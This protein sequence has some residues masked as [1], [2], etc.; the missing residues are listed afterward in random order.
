MRKLIKS[1]VGTQLSEPRFAANSELARYVSP[2][3][4]M[5]GGRISSAAFLLK[6]GEEYLSV[7]SVEIES[8]QE[9]AAHYRRDI[10]KNNQKVA[11]ASLKILA[12]NRAALIAG[13]S[14]VRRNQ[15][16]FFNFQGSPL[17]AY[18]LRITQLSKSHCSVDFVRAYP[19]ELAEK[20][21][22]WKMASE[23]RGRKPHLL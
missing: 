3:H 19:S 13:I 16:W 20:K 7:N 9:I 5:K 8:L 15:T 21:F 1:K 2:L 6:L 14:I 22:A 11:V 10:Q 4:L 23:P 12:Y 17:P 18:K